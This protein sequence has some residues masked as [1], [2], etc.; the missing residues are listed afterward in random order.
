MTRRGA[1]LLAVV[2]G[3]LFAADVA[4]AQQ[5][6]LVDTIK[7]RGK[8]QVGFATFLPWAMRDK[9]GNWVGFEIDVPARWAWH[10]AATP[11][12]DRST[13]R[14]TCSSPSSTGR[15]ATPCPPTVVGSNDAS[16]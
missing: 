13:S 14:P 4:L 2:L 1:V 12:G 3:M 6:S 11:T 8:L 15:A 9:Q 10:C 7:K 5:D 16:P